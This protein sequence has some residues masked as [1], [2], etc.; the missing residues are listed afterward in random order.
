[1]K[2]DDNCHVIDHTGEETVL[3][4]FILMF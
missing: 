3:L 4:E 2:T 1:V